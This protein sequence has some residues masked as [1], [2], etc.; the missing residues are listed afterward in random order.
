MIFKTNETAITFSE[1][2]NN[3]KGKKKKKFIKFIA[4]SNNSQTLD[5]VKVNFK[6]ININN[7]LVILLENNCLMQVKLSQ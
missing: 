1:N 5:H 6:S 3:M 7:T 2:F 4:E